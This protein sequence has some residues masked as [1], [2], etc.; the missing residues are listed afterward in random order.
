MGD[1]LGETAEWYNSK[2]TFVLTGNNSTWF[3]RGGDATSG[4]SIFSFNW[5][6]GDTDRSKTSRVVLSIAE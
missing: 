3:Y 1:S 2:A 5:T 6:S 4:A